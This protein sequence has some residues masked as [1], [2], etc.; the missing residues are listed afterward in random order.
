MGRAGGMLVGTHNGAVDE[1]F[2]EVGVARKP[3]KYR[4]PHL[5]PRPSGKAFVHTVPRSEI[6]R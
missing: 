6:G 3:S 1:D 4:V 5:R 2:L